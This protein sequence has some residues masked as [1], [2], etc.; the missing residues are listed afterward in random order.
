MR[1]VYTSALQHDVFARRNMAA[2]SRKRARAVESIKTAEDS[3]ETESEP[4]NYAA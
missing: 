1:G 4:D 2:A 3:E